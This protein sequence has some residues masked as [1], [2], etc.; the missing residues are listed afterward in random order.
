VPAYASASVV[1]ASR[2]ERWRAIALARY[3]HISGTPTRGCRRAQP[4]PQ[5]GIIGRSVNFSASSVL[6]KRRT[7]INRGEKS[8]GRSAAIGGRQDVIAT[9]TLRDFASDA[10][11]FHWIEML[12]PDLFMHNLHDADEAAALPA[13][14]EQRGAQHVRRAP[15]LGSGT[16]WRR[17]NDRRRSLSCEGRRRR[18]DGTDGVSAV[19]FDRSRDLFA[20]LDS[21]PRQQCGLTH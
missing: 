4:C 16:R 21:P 17:K 20:T 2:R 8:G 12:Y 9:R 18:S 3:E 19:R 11:V 14:P 1:Q 7:L 6:F 15:Y 13:V 5:I 10:L